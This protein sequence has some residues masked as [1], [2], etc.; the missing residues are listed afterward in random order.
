MQVQNKLFLVLVGSPGLV[1]MGGD[2]M[3]IFHMSIFCKISNVCLK[4]TKIN[5][6]R[7]RLAHLKKLF[8]IS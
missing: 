8:S 1:V 6:K 3:D 2:S 4:K 7:P 5:E